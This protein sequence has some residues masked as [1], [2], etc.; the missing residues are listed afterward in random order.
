DR[1]GRDGAIADRA[2]DHVAERRLDAGFAGDMQIRAGP[3][4]VG[5]DPAVRVR[6]QTHG[7]RCARVDADYVHEALDCMLVSRI[8]NSLAYSGRGIPPR[9][10]VRRLH[11]PDMRAPRAVRCGRRAPEY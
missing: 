2:P 7:F 4:R 1:V 8:R 11:I 10:V 9:G 5:E 6:E 3:S